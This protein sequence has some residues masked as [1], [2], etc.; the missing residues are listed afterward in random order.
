MKVKKFFGTSGIQCEASMQRNHTIMGF[1][2]RVMDNPM[3]D[4]TASPAI[5]LL[6]SL[7]VGLERQFDARA[8]SRVWRLVALPA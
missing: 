2:R 4:I 7:L 8:R 1:F 5:D 6:V 3:E